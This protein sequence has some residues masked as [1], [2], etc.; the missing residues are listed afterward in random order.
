[1]ISGSSVL[2]LS[3]E[4]MM[5]F[6]NCSLDAANLVSGDSTNQSLLAPW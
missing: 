4:P 3:Y 6:A 5:I 1:M 2:L